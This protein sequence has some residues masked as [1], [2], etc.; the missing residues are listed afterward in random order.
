MQKKMAGSA[1]FHQ[2]DREKTKWPLGGCSFMVDHNGFKFFL[3]EDKS[4]RFYY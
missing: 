4:H 2:Q 1:A 3:R